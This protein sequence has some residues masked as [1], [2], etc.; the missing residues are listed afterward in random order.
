MKGQKNVYFESVFKVIEII[1]PNTLTKKLKLDVDDMIEVILPIEVTTGG[2]NG[3]Y[4]RYVDITN[5]TSGE[6]VEN[7][8]L[9]NFAKMIGVNFILEQ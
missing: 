5:I 6:M 2:S 7:M 8:S 1:K 9:N 4:A 3:L